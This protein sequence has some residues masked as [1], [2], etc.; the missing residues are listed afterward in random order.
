VL[1]G[2][3]V[4]GRTHQRRQAGVAVREDGEGLTRLPAL[5]QQGRAK[6]SFRIVGTR[7]HQAKAAAGLTRGFHLAGD[8]L[9]KWRFGPSTVARTYALSRVTARFGPAELA[10]R[11]GFSCA[12][13]GTCSKRWATAQR[14]L[15]TLAWLVVAL[16]SRVASSRAASRKDVLAPNSACALEH[17]RR[18]DTLFIV[19]CACCQICAAGATVFFT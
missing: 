8:D 6:G 15:R 18:A 2:S 17:L 14:W 10:G 3:V 1:D 4:G 19:L 9:P 12:G 5:I 7:A 13:G 11:F 16:G